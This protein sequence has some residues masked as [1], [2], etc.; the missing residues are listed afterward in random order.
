MARRGTDA[1]PDV[2]EESL[3]DTRTRDD[4]AAAVAAERATL[5][6]GDEDEDVAE[7][8]GDSAGGGGDG[9]ERDDAGG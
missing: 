7:T 6:N 5:E 3:D 9:D 8:R 4:I 2:V 1:N